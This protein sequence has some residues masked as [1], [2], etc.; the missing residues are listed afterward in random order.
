[1]SDLPQPTLLEIASGNEKAFAQLYEH[2]SVQLL[3]FAKSLL[4]NNECAEEAVEDVFIGVWRN[5]TTIAEVENIA[6]YLY[7][8]TKNKCLT[9]LSQKAKELISAPYEFLD[10]QIEDQSNPYTIMASDEAFA[11]M[12]K[13]INTLP[14]KC[15]MI[16]KLVRE[17]GLKYKEVAQI[18]NISVNTIDVHMAIAVKR[19]CAAMEIE[20]TKSRTKPHPLSVKEIKK[21]HFPLVDIFKM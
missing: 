10:V 16:F 17:D 5:R 6:V 13:A 1:M 20:K 15:K 3:R 8:A 2:F 4:R 19:I 21:I 9:I 14:P 12:K 11:R 7:V 18:L